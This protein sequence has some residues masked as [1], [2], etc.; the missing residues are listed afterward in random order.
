MRRRIRSLLQT[1][2][3]RQDD[4]AVYCDLQHRVFVAV[5]VREAANHGMPPDYLGTFKQTLEDCC[6]WHG[7][8]CCF[9]CFR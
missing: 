8:W 4:V 1:T 3:P 7:V 5:A 6:P 9:R 2:R